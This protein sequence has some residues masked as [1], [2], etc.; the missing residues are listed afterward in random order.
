MSAQ[1]HRSGHEEVQEVQAADL[2]LNPGQKMAEQYVQGGL[3][4]PYITLWSRE[5]ELRPRL[6]KK[7]GRAGAFLGYR[8]EH[9]CDRDSNGALWRRYSIAPGKG[10]AEFRLVHAL[11][12]RNAMI[13]SLCQVCR[14]S[15]L[16]SG[17][18][19]ELFVINGA[20]EQIAEGQRTSAPPV[21]GRCAPIAARDCPHLRSGFAAAW[22]THSQPWGVMG[23]VYDLDTLRPV[24]GME[25]VEVSY[26]NPLIM[27]VIAHRMVKALHG[28]TAVAPDTV[29]RAEL[30]AP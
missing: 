28:C 5:Q 3:I 24:D 16:E 26:L 22:V 7:Y 6:E 25:N 20:G 30:A 13:R 12:Q 27:Q 9:D 10:R 2:S 8:D 11:R 4:V 19:Q 18:E 23:T 17:H 1:E 21:C 29:R 14:T 15:L